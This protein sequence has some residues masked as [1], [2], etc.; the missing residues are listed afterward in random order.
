[1]IPRMHPIG[2]TQV[3]EDSDVADVT[4]VSQLQEGQEKGFE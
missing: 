2:A 4:H 1:M 3:D